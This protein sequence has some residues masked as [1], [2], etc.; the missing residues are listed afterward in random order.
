MFAPVNDAFS[1]PLLAVRFPFTTAAAAF[2]VC[3]WHPI[4]ASW[5]LLPDHFADAC[6][7]IWIVCA[8]IFHDD[9]CNF[10]LY[11]IAACQLI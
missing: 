2:H 5:L 8:L 3:P 10:Q 6:C 1:E 7:L 9:H 11:I 4:D